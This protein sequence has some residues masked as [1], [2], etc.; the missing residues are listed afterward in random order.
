MLESVDDDP[1]DA[2]DTMKYLADC[3]YEGDGIEKSYA[4][5]Y[6]LYSIYE[7]G[8]NFYKD[9]VCS[10]LFDFHHFTA[11]DVVRHPL[12]ARIID[13][14]EKDTAETPPPK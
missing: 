11:T 7:S 6:T 13:A 3:L 14:Y 4:E 8:A 10:L 2:T 1:D 5:A 9:D 12:V